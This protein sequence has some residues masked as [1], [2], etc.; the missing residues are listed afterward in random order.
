M[1]WIRLDER[2][3]R[4]LRKD[5]TIEEGYDFNWRVRYNYAWFLPLNKKGLIPGSFQG[6]INNEIMFNFGKN[7]VFNT[8]DQNRLFV[9]LVYQ[10]TKES[11]LQVGYMNVFQQQAI[12]NKYRS[13]HCVRVFYTHNVDLRKNHS[14][15]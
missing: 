7:I 4:T 13:L 3:R 9:G 10:F 14:V 11:H 12:G 6:L 1:Q 2:F 15:H 5:G 8:F